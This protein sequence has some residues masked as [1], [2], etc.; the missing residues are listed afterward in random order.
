MKLK[1]TWFR[2]KA[3]KKF[4]ITPI[5]IFILLVLS[6]IVAFFAGEILI[7]NIFPYPVV[8]EYL[9]FGCNNYKAIPEKRRSEDYFWKPTEEFRKK[10][11]STEKKEDVFRIICIGDSITQG[12]AQEKGLLPAHETYVY[13][14]EEILALQI[15]SKRVEV[16]NA[17]MGGYSSL[18]GLRYLKNKLWKYGPDLV[19]SWFGVNDYFHSL[20]YPDKEQKLPAHNKPDQGS[21]LNKS[22]LIKFFK[23]LELIKESLKNPVVRVSPEDFYNNSE[24]MLK[25]AQKKGFEIIF[26]APFQYGENNSIEYF[27]G[28]PE[29]LDALAEKYGCR[30]LHLKPYFRREDLNSLY[31][32]FCHFN[33]KGNGV[34]AKILFELLKEDIE[35]LIIRNS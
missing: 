28:Y 1:V 30:V 11:Y 16:I 33:S 34:V 23:N 29:E 19:I 5:G 12:D 27:A 26:I 32:D 21:I 3:N 9:R 24:E 17:G 18:Q 4:K 20:F 14:L 15:K 13:K 22:K 25:L 7:R 8:K 6:T 2:K 35:R 31:A 10:K